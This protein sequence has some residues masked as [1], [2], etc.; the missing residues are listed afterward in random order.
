MALGIGFMLYAF[1]LARRSET[2]GE[3]TVSGALA[4]AYGRPTKLTTPVIMIFALQIMA[5]STY[6]GGSFFRA[7]LLGADRTTAIV[8]T[9]AV[10]TFYV[11]IVG[12]RSVIYTNV[13]HAL[14]KRP[15]AA[16]ISIVASLV[17]TIGWFL[18]RDPFG[19]DNAYVALVIPL[20]VMATDHLLKRSGADV[21]APVAVS[22]R[23]K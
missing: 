6:A 22:R 4:R 7:G 8:M 18:A 11:G 21:P 19:I 14:V 3:N 1:F 15:R 13:L 2:I 20:V 12:M 17:L 16:F 9:G 5:I 23:Q 10:A